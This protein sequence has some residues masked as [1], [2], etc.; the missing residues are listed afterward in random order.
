M[1]TGTRREPRKF[2]SASLAAEHQL[3]AEHPSF[4]QVRWCAGRIRPRCQPRGGGV[5]LAARSLLAR[6]AASSRC[7]P[8]YDCCIGCFQHATARRPTGRHPPPRCRKLGQACVCSCAD[9]AR[10]PLAPWMQL[11]QHSSQLGTQGSRGSQPALTA[12]SPAAARFLSVAV[13]AGQPRHVQH[14]ISSV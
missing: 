7:M 5:S 10:R 1:K 9:S 2:G 3:E 13:E 11:D 4:A 8:L 6:R 12:R 14:R